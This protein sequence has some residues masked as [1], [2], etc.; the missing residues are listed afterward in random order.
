MLIGFVG[1]VHGLVYHALAL[2]TTWQRKTGRKLDLVVQVGDMGAYPSLDRMDEA[3]RRHIE[4]DSAQADFSRLPQTDGT[5][6]EHLM[7][8]ATMEVLDARDEETK[9][10]ASR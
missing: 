5:R 7:R 2:V 4:L 6:A 1:D 9:P 10:K 3:G 8:C